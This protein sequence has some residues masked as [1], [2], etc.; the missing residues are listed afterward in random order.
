MPEKSEEL[1]VGKSEVLLQQITSL[2]PKGLNKLKDNLRNMHEIV[3]NSNDLA[4]S[5]GANSDAT[6]PVAPEATSGP[7]K[8]TAHPDASA[9][10]GDLLGFN[11]VVDVGDG[12]GSTFDE[13]VKQQ[14]YK[15]DQVLAAALAIQEKRK[16]AV[17][18]GD[19]TLDEDVSQQRYKDDQTLAD[20]LAI[21]EKRK[22]AE[23]SAAA[24]AA[25]PTSPPLVAEK[26]TETTAGVL[27]MKTAK[28]GWLAQLSQPR[29]KRT[30]G[31]ENDEATGPGDGVREANLSGGRKKT[32]KLKLKKTLK[33][34]KNSK[35]KSKRR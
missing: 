10:I 29:K 13:D 6:S 8:D 21:Q 2:S 20:A 15:D 3:R 32:R 22:Q 7:T 30:S 1:L 24:R 23:D 35:R 26:K 5:N 19:S 25:L 33:R 28:S 12:N 27:P 34:R 14:Q 18:A 11:P 16:Q 17:E 4:S 31:K 9:P